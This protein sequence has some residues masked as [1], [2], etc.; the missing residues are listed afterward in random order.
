MK[1]SSNSALQN[2]IGF[3]RM[4]DEELQSFTNEQLVDRYDDINQQAHFLQG[5]ILLELRRRFKSDVFFG[6]WIKENCSGTLGSTTRQHRTKLMNLVRYFEKK[7]LTGILI[8]SAYE[9]SAPR[10]SAVADEI[11]QYALNKN[12]PPKE[13]IKQIAIAKNKKGIAEA[14]EPEKVATPALL[15]E[16]VKVVLPEIDLKEQVKL[17]IVDMPPMDAIRLL[18]EIIKEIQGSVYGKKF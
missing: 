16:P 5:Q 1:F 12:L 18:S 6:Q 9:I 17:L 8:T 11:Y 14:V 10:N 3:V 2:R 7:D 4:A 15:V 13:V